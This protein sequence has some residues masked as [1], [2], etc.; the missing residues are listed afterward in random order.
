MMRSPKRRRLD[1]DILRES[2]ITTDVMDYPA[3][4]ID[5]IKNPW[6]KRL[7]ERLLGFPDLIPQEQLVSYSSPVISYQH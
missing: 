3:V 7:T 4:I 1:V 6:A 2:G 5:N